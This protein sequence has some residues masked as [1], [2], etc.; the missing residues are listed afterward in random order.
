MECIPIIW[1]GECMNINPGKLNKR[2][3]IQQ[4]TAIKDDNANEILK[5]S[6][7]ITTWAE[8]NNLYGQEYWAAAAHGQEDT[9]VFTVRHS[10][11]LQRLADTEK[12][13]EYRIIFRGI[14]YN[15]ASYDNVG[16]RN[17]LVKIKA[18]RR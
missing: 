8:V 4:H 12:L 14:A 11:K 18:V 7:Y 3:T 17:K 10:K 15:I 13:T 5:W 16:Y 6:D 1:W 2:I 9:V